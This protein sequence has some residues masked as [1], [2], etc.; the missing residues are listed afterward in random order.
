MGKVLQLESGK[1]FKSYLKLIVE[2]RGFEHVSVERISEAFEILKESE[3]DII[4]TANQLQDGTGEEFLE[5][6]NKTEY[7]SIPVIILTSTESLELREKLFSLG[8]V[9]YILKKDMTVK[10]LENYFDTILRQDTLLK[11]IQK[12]KI[13]VLD[14]SRLE[15][16]LISNIFKLNKINN[17]SYYTDPEEFLNNAE[18]F[19]FYFVD[20][21]LPGYS[22]EEII[23][24]LRQKNK[25]C[26]I[27]VVSGISN[28]KII[29]HAIMHGADDYITKPF[30]NAVFMARLKAN[31]RSF[32]LYKEIEKM[33]VTDSLTGLFNHKYIC[34]L[35][36][37][38]ARMKSS[39][40]V[41]FSIVLFDID[42]FK[43]VNDT[44]GH[45][46]GD[47]VLSAVAG[48]LKS[49][50]KEDCICGRYGGEEFLAVIKNCTLGKAFNAA[51]KFREKVASIKFKD[52]D[53]SI[54]ISGGVA[55]FS[56]ESGSELIKKSDNYLYKAKEQ[57]RNRIIYK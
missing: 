24:Q 38:M 56:G 11:K 44:Y 51:Q 49:E 3:I 55:Q 5:R 52:H 31:A 8:I 53:F 35:V 37:N 13:A 10:R 7:A 2:T 54:T 29:S 22:G 6:L 21:V 16:T 12:E 23:V 39:K 4:V 14:D 43:S 32:F 25:N 33:A 30:D 17:V 19:S 40:K 26:V 57:G 36:Y 20:M 47:Y 48:L 45:Q 42:H 46:T 1:L 50:F 15:L 9:D 27:I 41:P 18:Q 34:D 28:F